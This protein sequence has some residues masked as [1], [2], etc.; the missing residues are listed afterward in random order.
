MGSALI[1]AAAMNHLERVKL[2]Y[3]HGPKV[4]LPDKT[5]NME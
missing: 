3:S 5:G 4:N 1:P 2:L